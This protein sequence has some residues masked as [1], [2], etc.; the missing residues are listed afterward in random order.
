MFRR[1]RHQK[2]VAAGFR[3]VDFMEQFEANTDIADILLGEAQQKPEI[4]LPPPS[5][6]CPF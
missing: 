3:V 4:L 1:G 6:V 2:E 5:D